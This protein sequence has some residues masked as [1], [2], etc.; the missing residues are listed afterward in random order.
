MFLVFFEEDEVLFL[1]YEVFRVYR[2]E[3]EFL[4]IFLM[5]CFDDLFV[6]RYIVDGSVVSEV[7]VLVKKLIE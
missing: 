2:V 1:L 3:E 7:E 4:R 5:S 6:D